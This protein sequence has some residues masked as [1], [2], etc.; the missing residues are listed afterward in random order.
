MLDTVEKYAY[1]FY[2]YLTSPP[3]SAQRR[4][5]LTHCRAWPVQSRTRQPPLAVVAAHAQGNR[6]RLVN[7]IGSYSRS[8]V[9][10]YACMMFRPKT[11]YKQLT[12]HFYV[13][14]FSFLMAQV[15]FFF[16]K[17]ICL[18]LIFLDFCYVFCQIRATPSISN[19]KSFFLF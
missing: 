4:S 15:C 17:Y 3:P 18:R 11:T 5:Q 12:G 1:R 8:R 6:D 19:Y 7:V 14:R 10:L 2:P 16:K 13:R 9:A